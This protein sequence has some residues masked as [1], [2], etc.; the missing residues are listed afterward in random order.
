[1]PEDVRLWAQTHQQLLELVVEELL[2]TGAW[3][4]LGDLTRRLV[5]EQRPVP[6]RSIF[7]E[8]PK[9][10]GFVE[11][12]PERV[13]LTPFG[14][15]MTHAGHEL[16]DGLTA[17][18]KLAAER[19]E[20]D[21]SEPVITRA[22]IAYK[23]SASEPYVSAL[24][25]ILLRGMPFLG[26]G[27]GGAGDEW[28]REVTDDIVRYWDARRTEAYLRTRAKELAWAGAARSGPASATQPGTNVAETGASRPG[29]S[30]LRQVISADAET[31]QSAQRDVFIAHASE[32]KEPIARPLVI[33]LQRR[34]HSV[35][36][37]DYELVLGDSLRR[38]IDAGLAGATV[39]VVIL[40]HAFLSKQWPRRELDGLTAR[41]TS[42]E[43]NVLVPI[44]HELT[45]AELLSY[46]PPLADLLAAR[47][48]QGVEAIASEIERVL[49][50]RAQSVTGPGLSGVQEST[51]ERP[52]EK[53]VRSSSAAPSDRLGGEAVTSLLAAGAEVALR[54]A[55]RAGRGELAREIG[56][57]SREHGA[58]EP[59]LRKF[60]P[61]LEQQMLLVVDQTIPLIRHR[62]ALIDEQA[63]WLGQ[64]GAKR[65]IYWGVAAW[66]E[67]PRWIAW[68]I[69]RACG[70][71]AVSIDELGAVRAMLGASVDHGI[72]GVSPESLA[73][74]GPGHASQVASQ[75]AGGASAS[76][77]WLEQWSNALRNSPRLQ[78]AVPEFLEGDDQGPL[79]WLLAYTLL[80]TVF[81]GQRQQ[82]AASPWI[83]Y[84]DGG[85]AL[86]ARLHRDDVF[87]AHLADTVFRCTADEFRENA[88]VW[89]GRG[90]GGNRASPLSPF[91]SSA[92]LRF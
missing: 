34:G 63:H 77:S 87:L 12:N 23:T 90:L 13:V 49:M 56:T 19:Y 16:L 40:S 76:A 84:T 33:E 24:S 52:G 7:W 50:R 59:V 71:Y 62:S 54:E 68:C 8:M 42:G 32:D 92:S 82:Q 27:A 38:K 64:L 70:A 75:I 39:G 79:G 85:Y 35:W 4:P 48:D 22:D 37:D 14:L 44:W 69:S 46:S 43:A 45:E 61:T 17:I 6:L 74:I 80:C 47:S 36:F 81:S 29:V 83:A 67:L 10:L 26:A 11:T 3:Q 73:S 91:R 57:L 21:D 2:R 25:E 60:F 18:L 5:R 78:M 66:V 58:S 28:R 89:L 31:N 53:E 86:T 30:Q 1:M 41:L 51:P 9:E 15:R 88:D 72:P 20:S 65:Y 55:L